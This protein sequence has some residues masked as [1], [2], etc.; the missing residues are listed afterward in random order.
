[1]TQT[2]RDRTVLAVAALLSVVAAGLTSRLS[3]KSDLSYLLPE[4]TPSVR[5][6]RA[7]E[8]PGAV[9]R[10]GVLLEHRDP[11]EAAPVRHERRGVISLR[12]EEP[13]LLARPPS[14]RARRDDLEARRGV[15]RCRRPRPTWG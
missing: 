15:T 1:M 6:L 2:S 8:G 9:H 12:A 10:G 14:E 13:D 4:S 5:Q 11:V 7:I 3:I